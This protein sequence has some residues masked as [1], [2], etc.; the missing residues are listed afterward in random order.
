M[1]R[2]AI[3]C[4]STMHRPYGVMYDVVGECAQGARRLF[5]WGV[6]DC[7]GRCPPERDCA[8][9]PLWGECGGRA[10]DHERIPGHISIEDAA[11]LKARVG[12]AQ[13]E[14]EMLCLRPTRA[15]SVLPEF[16]EA[17]HVYD[18]EGVPDGAVVGGMDFG[19]R[20][21]TVVLLAA[22]GNDGVLR[23]FAEYSRAGVTMAEHAAAIL[24]GLGGGWPIPRGSAP[25]PPARPRRSPAARAACGCSKSAA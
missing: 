10:K 16:S 7:L 12:L 20:N 11:A 2:G 17:A 25:T 22:L 9:C 8:S 21:P 13:W 1:V 19:N 4:L 23:V 3:E 18:G 6:A 15:D 24:A 5:R 14:T